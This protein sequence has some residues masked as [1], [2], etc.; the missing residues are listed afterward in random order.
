MTK[1]T[2]RNDPCPCG[3]GN[4]YKRCCMIKETSSHLEQTDLE[5]SKLRQLEGTVFDRH[6][7]P[8][9]TK[10][11]PNEVMD[12]AMFEGIP[13]DLPEAL[14]KELLFDN[15]FFPW[16]LFNW[17]PFEDFGV[18][19]FEPEINLAK[20]YIKIHEKRLNNQEK[21]F[22][23]AM[24]R[25]YYSYYS[26]L[27][28][29]MDKSLQVKDIM[30]GTTHTIKEREG[31]HHLKRGDIVFSRILTLDN[32]SIFVGMVPFT[33]P[34]D[35]YNSLIDFR[36][37]LIEENDDRTLDPEVLRDE[38]DLEL[39]DYLF[40]L[41]KAAYNR[42]LPT[43]VNTD[44][45][46]LQFSKSHFMIRIS[47][48]EALNKL[49]PL[50]L[51]DDPEEF[52]HGAK[53]NKS[54]EIKQIEFPW[55][56]RGNKKHKSWDNTILGYIA[57]KKDQLTLETNSEKRMQKG[58]NLLIKYLGDAISF[59]KTLIESLE[60]KLKSLPKT[61]NTKNQEIAKLQESPEVQEQLKA[62]VKAHW[63]NWFDEPIPALDNETP[64]EAAETEEGKEKLEALLLLYERYDL[65]KGDHPFKADIN[66]LRKELA[67]D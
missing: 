10:E 63:E 48:E 64:R 51:S 25:S 38:L 62:M 27:Q 66:Y 43:L 5:W 29:E 31:T 56:K 34:V 36:K 9:A 28:V 17:I 41:I 67:L 7:I 60:R 30:L 58:K 47:P 42:P 20:N 35:Y 44:G 1:K 2:G 50:T 11:L 13:P 6:L 49:L 26:V 61:E 55:I 40:D 32:Q 14:D 59:Q 8:Y 12:L 53:R 16:F 21:R 18:R 65:E 22:I 3:S 46:L 23:E 15:F 37:W 54:G 52:L 4:K 19:Q 45:E 33:I 57:I 24:N 39:L